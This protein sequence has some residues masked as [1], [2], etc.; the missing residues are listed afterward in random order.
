MNV[1]RGS[2]RG[3]SSR[4]EEREMK[5]YSGVKRMEICCIYTYEDSIMR[6]TKH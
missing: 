3:V 1:Y 5:R 6:P 4:G 2:V